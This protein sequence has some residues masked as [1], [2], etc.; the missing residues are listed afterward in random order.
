MERWTAQDSAE[1]RARISAADTLLV[2]WARW[3]RSEGPWRVNYPRCSSFAWNLKSSSEESQPV[4][5]SRAPDGFDD[6][7][8]RVDALLSHWRMTRKALWKLVKAEYLSGGSAET[9]AKRLRMP[10][11]TYRQQ[12]DIMRVELFTMLM[13]ANT[14]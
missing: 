8:M 7:M 5:R 6:D 3:Q 9:K 1:T 13:H 14:E 11:T 10:R 12:L 4:A 2:Q